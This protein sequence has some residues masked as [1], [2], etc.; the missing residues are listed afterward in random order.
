MK[1]VKC[2]FCP[3]EKVQDEE[4]HFCTDCW[5]ALEGGEIPPV[6]FKEYF[7]EGLEQKLKDVD[8]LLFNIPENYF[9]W[10][11]KGHLEHELG[12]T[13][14]ALN[15]I[16]TSI[17]YKEDYGDP[18]IRLGL[19]FS[20][21]HKDTESIEHYKKGLQF[22]LLDP[23][24]LVDAGVSLQA[25]DQPKLASQLLQK[26]LDLLPEE[27][28]ALVALGK[29]YVQT[30]ELREARE[31]LQK[32][33]E[34][35]PHN[36]EVLRGMAQILL[37]L[38]DLDSA[39]EMYS[40]ILDQH[41][42]DFEALLA[43]GEIHLR[44]RELTQSIK[45][46]QAVRDLDIHIS[47]SGIL[48]FIVTNLRTIMD[49]NE[50]SLSYR[51]D[52]KKE[53]EN[54]ILFLGELEDKVDKE[55]GPEALTEIESL[56]KVLEN[57][58][59]NLKDQVRQFEDLLEKFKVEDSFHKH[60][61]MK[62][63]N[64]QKYLNEN[65]YFDGKQ[66]ALELAPF[67]TD[68]K[69]RD[70]K[71]ES[72]IK[73]RM[74]AKFE[75]LREI[76]MENQ[77]LLI[78]FQMVEDL[79]KEGNQEGAVFMLKEIEVSLEE[80]WIDVTK[81][82]HRGRL[83]EMSEIIS[84]AKDQFDTSGLNELYRSFK[85]KGDEGA[86]VITEAF[87]EFMVRYREDSSSYY[88]K[89]AERMMK[90]LDLQ[91]QLM[92][93]DGANTKDLRGDLEK[94]G[95]ELETTQDPHDLHSRVMDLKKRIGYFEEQLKVSKVRYRLRSLDTIL[96]EA[97]FLG[98]DEEIARNVEP[99]RRVIERSIKQENYRLSEILTNELFD[100]MEKL[101]R[102]NYTSK[103]QDI[104][105]STE[106][107]L[108]RLKGLG[109]DLK[110][111]SE[112]VDRCKLI[113]EGEGKGMMTEVITLLSKLQTDIQNFIIEKLPTEIDRKLTLC[114]EL[115]DEGIGYGFPLSGEKRELKNLEKASLE[116]S[117]L[118]ILE[119]AYRFESE[120]SAKI[121]KLLAR[122]ISDL[123]EK[124][125]D[126]LDEVTNLGVDQK[127]VMEILS[128]ANKSEVV[129]E[130]GERKEAWS[131]V[132]TAFDKLN[133]LRGKAYS[134]LRDR[135]MEE[136]N[137]LFDLAIGLDIETKEI[138]QERSAIIDGKETDPQRGL[139]LA[140][141]LHRKVM[142]FIKDGAS[143]RFDAYK[144]GYR[145]M[146]KNNLSLLPDG[147][148]SRMREQV[149]RTELAL[150]SGDLDELPSLLDETGK[151]LQE[152]VRQA[153]ERSVLNR[154]SDII[155]A[156][157]NIDDPRAREVIKKGQELI[158]KVRSG[159]VE[160]VEEQLQA[161]KLEMSSIGDL[162][163][164]QKVEKALTEVKELDELA[165]DVLDSIDDDR[166]T[167]RIDKINRK[168]STLLEGTSSLYKDTDPEQ[169]EE[170]S[171]NIAELND[172]IIDLEQ[173]WRAQRR[174]DILE[175]MDLTSKEKT[176]NLLSEDIANLGQ[177]FKSRDWNRFFRTWERLEGHI[178]KMETK[179]ILP[180]GSSKLMEEAPES[181]GI[182]ILSRKRA[183]RGGIRRPG[184][185]RKTESEDGISRLAKD[186]AQKKKL[187]ENTGKGKKAE[188]SPKEPPKK[189][190]EK[191]SKELAEMARSIAGARI[192]KLKKSDSKALD[193]VPILDGEAGEM[194][195]DMLDIDTSMEK[196]ETVE[197]EHVR[198]KLVAFF[199]RFPLML[200]LD[201]VKSH[202]KKGEELLKDGKDDE[203][204][205]EYRVAM[206]TAIKVGKIHMDMGKKLTTVR[207][208][209]NR[210]SESGYENWEAEDLYQEASTLFKEGDLLGCA[211]T[212]KSIR[213]ALA[214]Q[215]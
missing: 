108:L 102:E 146:L 35:Y 54:I 196:K 153:K 92:E 144:E 113:I 85:T 9:L 206:S 41:P 177:Q 181:P 188:K 162:I 19:I 199:R 58:R 87:D 148:A 72:K 39:M 170:L 205:K 84:R 143:E 128:M 83:E 125:R 186:M 175:E 13:K 81:H 97:D 22:T 68:L 30:G 214:K 20:D 207:S 192:E 8:S 61:K 124:T 130:T 145:E 203:A 211:R 106:A 110:E 150:K 132:N 160:G 138:E 88:R 159:E 89:E 213:D 59:L 28:R 118:D 111:W 64:L 49:G 40:R 141:S 46:Y 50:N 73:Q 4:V 107:E 75:E 67:L 25:S 169:V 5:A 80:Y 197:A 123:I 69:S 78:R 204:L 27:D 33:I 10:Y 212:I 154:C 105:A 119:D 182:D 114:R 195:E 131:L 21:M 135:K 66:I 23:S 200:Q 11:L 210:L 187:I 183:T 15:S 121:S 129:L 185:S 93:K 127:P 52:L 180:G 43:K 34:L 38:E 74:K 2:S 12:S 51:D 63:K 136:V 198:E 165:K 36:E 99:V 139:R 6:D 151:L 155:E 37:K 209:L 120:L 57:L 215:S 109:S 60:L 208:T 95:S 55:Q 26:A 90:E 126:G 70:S 1:Q 161:L 167:K 32:G 42:Q 104:L 16:K 47:W 190:D 3:S 133:V 168:I 115:V 112:S 140:S 86:R 191:G 172:D 174:L 101:L 189:D 31:V 134:D 76:G 96:G 14:K 202:F 156:A 176:D 82:Y 158:K 173:E 152:A 122:S 147:T 193:E 24:N 103:L 166:F 77:D 79:E 201:E 56:V 171:K 157:M 17:S 184:P 137:R 179:G 44:K 29:V 98:M 142:M 194:I 100:N 45:S 53:Y 149:R 48:K 164:M 65:R 163:H 7:S 91:V 116:I 178:R 94:L 62:V 117:S 71:T 18:W